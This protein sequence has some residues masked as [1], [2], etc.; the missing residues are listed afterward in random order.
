[1]KDGNRSEEVT[2]VKALHTDNLVNTAHNSA[3]P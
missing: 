3:M 1:L 2:F